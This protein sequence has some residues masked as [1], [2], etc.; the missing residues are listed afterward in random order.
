M[1][2]ALLISGYLR[3][4]KEN[5]HNLRKHVLNI[6]DIDIYIHVTKSKDS[7]Y[8]NHDISLDELYTLLNPKVLIVSNN[9]D[10]DPDEKVNNT[11]NQNYKFFLLNQKRKEIEKA[12]KITYKNIMKLR[13]DVFLQEDINLNVDLDK[14]CIPDDA[15]MDAHKLSNPNDKFICDII[16]YGNRRQMNDYFGFYNELRELLPKYGTVNETLLYHYLQ[17]NNIEYNLIHIYYTVLL[18]LCNTIAIT[19]DSGSGKTIV[20][21]IIKKI[22]DNSFVLECDRYH[23]WERGDKNWDIFTHLNPEANYI[24]KMENDVFN[25]KMGNNIYQID[26]DHTTG[27][28]TNGEIIETNDNII[29]CGLHSLYIPENIIN[30]KIY[31]DTDDNLRIPWK[32]KRD[33][34]KRGYTVDKIITQIYAR[35][36]D[37][38]EYIYPQREKADIIVN[39]YT[40]KIFDP[41]N[42]NPEENNQVFLKIGISDKYDLT[43]IISK[44]PKISNIVKHDN[45]LFLYFDENYDYEE[46]IK[47]IITNT[48]VHR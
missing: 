5:I 10:L 18:S 36:P 47:T 2:H 19:G 35:K 42:F 38:D 7:K 3:T 12:E 24:S 13:P 11:V 9:F 40:D 30:L 27:R 28:F 44:L 34:K 41:E 32:I 1:K 31:M 17:K 45:L 33:I 15:K 48:R 21:N 20:S 8:N 46:I 37:F 23:K 26:Y 43:I 6:N 39:F 16:A 14:I 22:F 29:V 4:F 25:L